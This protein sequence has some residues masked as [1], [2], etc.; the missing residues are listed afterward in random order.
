MYISLALPV[1]MLTLVVSFMFGSSG[2][3]VG[4]NITDSLQSR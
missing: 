4:K 1:R 3:F 2:K